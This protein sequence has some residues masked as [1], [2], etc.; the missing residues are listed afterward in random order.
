MY[1]VE[2]IPPF[3]QAMPDVI[4]VP[5]HA[6]KWKTLEQAILNKQFLAFGLADSHQSSHHILCTCM[7]EQCDTDVFKPTITEMRSEHF[8]QQQGPPW[9]S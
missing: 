2:S 1:S 7:V 4:D 6:A 8:M 5:S 3:H 9:V